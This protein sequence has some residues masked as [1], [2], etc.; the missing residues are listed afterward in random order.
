M[1]L[2]STARC[3]EGTRSVMEIADIVE[4]D[5][6]QGEILSKV[7]VEDVRMT[8]SEAGTDITEMF[9][10]GELVG[11]IVADIVDITKENIAETMYDTVVDTVKTV[12]LDSPG[13]STSKHV[14]KDP[15]SNVGW[16]LACALKD[17]KFHMCQK[18]K[19]KKHRKEEQKELK[20]VVI[21]LR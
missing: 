14:E 21:L 20:P 16:L 10:I 17:C 13:K 2:L 11:L 7:A 1:K 19:L 5:D 15:V 4:L 3:D 18:D 8:D 12:T 6:C 9:E